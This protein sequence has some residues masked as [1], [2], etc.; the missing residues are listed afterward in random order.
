M[1]ILVT[2]SGGLTTGN[3]NCFVKSVNSLLSSPEV[4]DDADGVDD[5]DKDEE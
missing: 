5:N 1:F 3:P 2:F 4:D